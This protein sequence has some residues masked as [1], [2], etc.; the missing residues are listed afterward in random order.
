VDAC[1]GLEVDLPALADEAAGSGNP[2]VPL[3]EHL[4]SAVPPHVAPYVHFGATSQDIHDS[5]TMLIADRSLAALLDDLRG[6]AGAAARLAREHRDTPM[7]ARTLLQLAVPTTFGL[8]AA[9][10][11]L[12]LDQAVSNLDRVRRT[13]LAVQYG[14]AAGT[15]AG[16][17]GAGPEVV[18][19]L[20]EDLGLAEPVLAWHTDRT[21][22]AELAGGLGEAAGA[23]AKAARD[24]IL[25]SQNE[26][27]EVSEAAP[28]GSSAM[29]HKRNPIAAISAVACAAQTPGL[30]ATLLAAMPAEHERGAGAW[31]AE[32]R[33]LR[34]L[35]I[36]TGSAAAWLRESLGTLAVHPEAMAS[37]L[38][39][40][41]RVVGAQGPEV[42]SA[43]VLVDRALA[44][45]EEVP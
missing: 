17:G 39:T 13:R 11:M 25:L 29:A 5:A 40:L 31:H 19:R 30:V 12:S 43:G 41:L 42:G 18:R 44:A 37:N 8:K 15:L 3:V 6:A 32:W 2:V 14:G 7:A 36:A 21:R 45:H 28:G 16:L 35:L 9:G 22:I 33:P 24:V 27:A 34:E 26:V 23:A 38:A 1:A 20:A 10:W 4:R